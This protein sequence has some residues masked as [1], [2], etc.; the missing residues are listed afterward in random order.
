MTPLLTGPTVLASVRLH[1]GLG[2]RVRALLG[3]KSLAELEHRRLVYCWPTG[4]PFG[5]RLTDLWAFDAP[6]VPTAV[7]RVLAVRY[8][9]RDPGLEWLDAEAR[10]ERI[11]QI[12][13]GSTL[14]LP[15][16]ATPWLDHL[17]AL[18]PAPAVAERVRSF[19]DEH[20]RGRAYVGVMIRA[21]AVSHTITQQ[22]SPVEWFVTRMKEIR[23]SHPDVAFFVSC[24]VPEVQQRVVAQFE[25]AVGLTD[26]GPYNSRAALVSSVA[27][28]YLL[29]SSAHVLAPHY[30][31]FPEL[32][33]YLAG[34]RLRLETSVTGPPVD[35]IAWHR[36]A[37]PLRPSVA[38]PPA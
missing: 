32:A 15:P 8:P 12:R 19:F 10:R 38:G 7:G 2:N 5:A 22:H 9:Y 25:D 26:K 27:D 3:A 23:A 18:R 14:S 29:A 1:A 34:D 35:G 20:L 21:H 6:R 4:K 31:S 30:S 37:D 33:Q 28:L 16:E 13:T 24:D 17:R 36:V 11:W